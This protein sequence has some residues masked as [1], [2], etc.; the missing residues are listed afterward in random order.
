MFL[1]PPFK[2]RRFLITRFRCSF[3]VPL[4]RKSRGTLGLLCSSGESVAGVGR[5]YRRPRHTLSGLATERR[6][7]TWSHYR[8]CGTSSAGSK[9]SCSTNW[10]KAALRAAVDFFR[11]LS[12]AHGTTPDAKCKSCDSFRVGGGCFG[13]LHPRNL[14]LRFGRQFPRDPGV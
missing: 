1:W 14:G 11:C 5:E 4:S 12:T 13:F 9:P 8:G 7:I 2:H 10:F 6:R 3:F